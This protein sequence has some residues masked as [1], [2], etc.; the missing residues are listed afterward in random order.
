MGDLGTFSPTSTNRRSCAALHPEILCPIHAGVRQVHDDYELFGSIGHGSFGEVMV[1]RQKQS[2][3]LRACKVVKIRTPEQLRIVKTEIELLK[4]LDHPNIMK[5][6]EAYFERVPHKCSSKMYLV[7]ELCEGGDMRSRIAHHYEELKKPMTESHVAYMM[8]QILSGLKCCHARG[9][10]HRDIK[11][12]NILFVDLSPGSSLKI[13]DFG[14]A[15]FVDKLRNNAGQVQVPREDLM[16]RF[17][18]SFPRIHKQPSRLRST[19]KRIMQMAGT[20]PYMAP[21][22]DS[23]SYDER[24]DMFSVGIVFCQMLTGRH[25]F[26]ASKSDQRQTIRLKITAPCPVELP[27]EFFHSVSLEAQDLCRGL[28]EKSPKKRLASPLALVHPWFAQ[29]SQ[30]LPYG[31]LPDSMAESFTAISFSDSVFQSLC[32]YQ[33]SHKLKRAVLQLM[34]RELPEEKVKTVRSQF[35]ALD[36]KGNGRLSVK[37]LATAL[38]ASSCFASAEDI[39]QVVVAIAQAG[40]DPGYVSYSEFVAALAWQQVDFHEE[41]LATCFRKLD[42]RG[43]GRIS[44][45]DMCDALRGSDVDEPGICES[46]WEDITMGVGSGGMHDRSEVTFPR[47]LALMML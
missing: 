15:D 46:E 23:G 7:A 44:Y 36:S 39:E 1:V 17:V 28:L 2:R 18:R 22:M 47:L 3:H 20:A 40:V 45:R 19:T 38:K 16:G 41:H 32:E 6:H 9:I 13:I 34:A 5:M 29:M 8:Q 25:P 21:E 11:P 30:A 35:M 14:L 43:L 33:A 10:V 31:N 26:N 42:R 27:P 12:E 24:A 4:T 37:E